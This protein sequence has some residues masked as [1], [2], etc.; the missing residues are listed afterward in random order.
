MY[1]KLTGGFWNPSMDQ[2][3]QLGHSQNQYVH[4]NLGRSFHFELI[5]YK[6]F[7]VDI[8]VL[9][10]LCLYMDVYIPFKHHK[11]ILLRN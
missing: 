3:A 11:H 2:G 4:S 1:L 7:Q 8:Q 5:Y 10:C 6:M 9:V